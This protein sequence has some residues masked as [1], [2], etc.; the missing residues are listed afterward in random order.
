MKSDRKQ[1][2]NEN[3]QN[4]RILNLKG[5]LESGCFGDNLPGIFWTGCGLFLLRKNTHAPL[6]QFHSFFVGSSFLLYLRPI[7]IV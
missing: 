3:K 2:S 1:I 4:N 5:S 6:L 7:T